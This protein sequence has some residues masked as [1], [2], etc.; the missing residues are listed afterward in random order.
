MSRS[1]PL[2][3]RLAG[4]RVAHATGRGPRQ[5]PVNLTV[6][7]T[8]SCPSRCATC[9]I[10]QKKVDDLSVDEYGRIFPTLHKVPV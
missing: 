2:L 3:A 4:Y 6:S 8:Y 9:D 1:L 7:V 10:W 5:L